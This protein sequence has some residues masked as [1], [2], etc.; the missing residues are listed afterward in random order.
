MRIV[1]VIGIT[2]GGLLLSSCGSTSSFIGDHLPEW[3]GGL[4]A[5]APPRRGEPGYQTYMQQVDGDQNAPAN[6]ASPPQQ[7]PTTANSPPPKAPG[8]NNQP[9]R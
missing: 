5:D 3:A 2:M 4:P 9:V 6:A 1:L 8:R 7:A